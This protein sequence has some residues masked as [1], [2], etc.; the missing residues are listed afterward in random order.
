M[1]QQLTGACW[2]LSHNPENV[3]DRQQDALEGL[4]GPNRPLYR[5]YLVMEALRLVFH[6]GKRPALAELRRW[7]LWARRSR[8]GLLVK[9]ARTITTSRAAIELAPRSA[10]KMQGLPISEAD[11]SGDK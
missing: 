8:L 4:A 3:T 7:F 10:W 2:A 5:A 11:S 6:V 1:A 9:L